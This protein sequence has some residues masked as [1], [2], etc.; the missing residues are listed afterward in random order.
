MI[1]DKIYH[2]KSRRNTGK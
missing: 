1:K 2:G